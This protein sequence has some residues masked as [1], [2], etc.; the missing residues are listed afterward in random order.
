MQET[1]RTQNVSLQYR[2]I[3]NVQ[4]IENIATNAKVSVELCPSMSAQVYICVLVLSLKNK[5]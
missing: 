2:G 3:K 5:W 4:P 1:T